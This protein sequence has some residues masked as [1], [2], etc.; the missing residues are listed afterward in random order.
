MGQSVL[1]VDDEPIIRESVSE[2][3]TGIGLSTLQAS[4]T[5]QALELLSQRAH[6]VAVLLT[7]IKMPGPMNGLDLARV[8]QK[9]WPWI[10]V[11]VMSGFWESGPE[12]LPDTAA[13]IAKPYLP[14][15][16]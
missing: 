10:R 1:I 6:T 14:E 11:I 16:W 12:G 8:A 15:N 4:D 7:D 9:S 5:P 2:L 3:L 13:F